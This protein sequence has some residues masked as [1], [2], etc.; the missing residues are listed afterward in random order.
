[1]PV[2]SAARRSVEGGTAALQW[3]GQQQNRSRSG[4][5]DATRLDEAGTESN[6]RLERP[7]VN[8]PLAEQ[9]RNPSRRERTEPRLPPFRS[10][11]ARRRGCWRDTTRTPDSCATAAV[12]RFHRSA[13][14]A[15]ATIVRRAFGR[16]IWMLHDPVIA[17]A[18]VVA[19]CG[20]S[21]WFARGRAGRSCIAANVAVSNGAIGS[22]NRRKQRTTFVRS[23][24]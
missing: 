10:D 13:M 20:R 16:S 14:A 4:F 5:G 8:G 22:P 18:P 17:R 12:R 11:L 15:I 3:P 6:R 19:R 1:M 2:R 7:A 24:D 21:A 23:S 9:A